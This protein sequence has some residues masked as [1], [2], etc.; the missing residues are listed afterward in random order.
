MAAVGDLRRGPEEARELD[1]VKLQKDFLIAGTL[2]RSF[3]LCSMASESLLRMNR[4][5]EEVCTLRKG[6]LS[7][8]QVAH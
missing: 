1:E 3:W 2:E 4:T 8:P 7:Q 6:F 5:S